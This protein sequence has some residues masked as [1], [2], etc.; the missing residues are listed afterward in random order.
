MGLAVGQ[1]FFQLLGADD[2]LMLGD[3]YFD[4]T[5]CHSKFILSVHTVYYYKQISEKVNKFYA[6]NS[7]II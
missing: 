3:L 2:D 5:A 1:R 4:L 6:K 7:A